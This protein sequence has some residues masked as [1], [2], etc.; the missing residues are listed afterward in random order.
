PQNTQCGNH[1][2]ELYTPLRSLTSCNLLDKDFEQETRCAVQHCRQW[3]RELFGFLSPRK[4]YTLSESIPSL[5][6]FLFNAS[7]SWTDSLFRVAITAKSSKSSNN[8][9]YRSIGRITAVFFPFLLTM[10]V[11]SVSFPFAI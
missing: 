5:F 9:W 6:N 4:I 7:Q 8:S 1:R 2:L 3:L 10:Y 11:A